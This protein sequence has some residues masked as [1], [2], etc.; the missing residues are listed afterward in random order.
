MRR[1]V[2][3][4]AVATIAAAL[5]AVPAAATTTAVPCIVNKDDALVLVAGGQF[6]Y[7]LDRGDTFY[8]NDPTDT[9]WVWGD[10]HNPAGGGLDQIQRTD[11]DCPGD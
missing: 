11:V 2:P 5:T 4:A 10:D 1:L 3:L 9:G 6:W 8:V 7:S